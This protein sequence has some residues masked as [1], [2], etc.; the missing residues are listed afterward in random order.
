MSES[1]P[2]ERS[3]P[4]PDDA[5]DGDDDGGRGVLRARL[6]FGPESSDPDTIA[7]TCYIVTGEH[8]GIT[9]PESF[10]RECHRF[11]RAADVAAERVGAPV[12]VRVVSWYTHVLGALRNGGYHP[13]V[14]VVDGTRLSQGH[15]VPSVEEVVAAIEAADAER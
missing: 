13:P 4:A 12:N 15:D 14:M 5:T 2:R 9:I 3:G 1:I 11:V 6:G 8:G 10:C 7:V